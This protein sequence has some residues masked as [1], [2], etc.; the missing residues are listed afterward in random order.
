M[1]EVNPQPFDKA[2]TALLAAQ[3]IEG[4]NA[5]DRGL[6]GEERFAEQVR[7]DIVVEKTTPAPG[8]PLP[9]RPRD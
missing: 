3:I 1:A 2:G 6:G 7:N 4:F 5:A 9:R 8:S